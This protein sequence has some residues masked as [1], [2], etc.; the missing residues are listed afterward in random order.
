MQ[1]VGITTDFSVFEKLDP[2]NI[3]TVQVRARKTARPEIIPVESEMRFE[4]SDL[5]LRPSEFNRLQR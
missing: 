5:R 1:R 2:K 3:G 4:P